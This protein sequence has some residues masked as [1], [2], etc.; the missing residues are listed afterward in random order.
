M[1][2]N[3][4]IQVY[5]SKTS[6]FNFAPYGLALRAAGQGFRTCVLYFSSPLP[7]DIIGDTLQMLD[8]DIVLKDLSRPGIETDAHTASVSEILSDGN[9]DLVICE[10]IHPFLSRDRSFRENLSRLCKEKSSHT[11][12][13]LTGPDAP[14]E[15]IEAADLVTEMIVKDNRVHFK[16][17]M[18]LP[19]GRTVVVT[20][21]GKGKTTYCLGLGALMSSRG[22]DT[23][24]IQYVKSA[25]PYGEI[26]GV[27]RF[28]T[29]DIISMG[30]GMVGG[31]AETA[32]PK[33][34]LAA[35]EAWT[36]SKKTAEA[37]KSGILI[38]DEINIAAR[39]E[40]ISI[41]QVEAIMRRKAHATELLLSGRDAAKEIE[42][43]ADRIVEMKKIKHPFDRGIKARRGIEF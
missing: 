9:C 25:R 37:L 16:E 43:A 13:V 36:L 14:P 23:R 29:F 17:P 6:C 1:L 7:L 40:W 10:G 34:Y 39:Y 24:M 21:D 12:W 28:P 11:E 38:L 41:G 4:L 2:E 3:G 8:A 18:D 20:G 33:H 22:T 15:M 26:K 5:T 31:T 35:Q 27:S 42:N 32:E 19:F 30:K